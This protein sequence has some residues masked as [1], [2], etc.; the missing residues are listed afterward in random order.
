LRSKCKKP[1][2]LMFSP[3]AN[4]A[5]GNFMADFTNTLVGMVSESRTGERVSPVER[6]NGRR[7]EIAAK[8][9]RRL[10]GGSGVF[11]A[12]LTRAVQSLRSER[13]AI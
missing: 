13:S 2:A 10:Q 5:R 9:A 1:P 4:T 12:A 7:C 8:D 3:T 6:R 11:E